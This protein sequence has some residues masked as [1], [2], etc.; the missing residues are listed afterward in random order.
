MKINKNEIYVK[1]LLLAI[2]YIRN[3]QSHKGRADR[4]C[5]YEAELVHNLAYTILTPAFRSRH[6]L[7]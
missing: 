7:S 3:V 2:P 4:S 1:M 6:L 5:Y